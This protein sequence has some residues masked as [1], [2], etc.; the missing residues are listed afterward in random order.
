MAPRVAQ[1][2][3]NAADGSKRLD[4]QQVVTAA[5][6][7]GATTAPAQPLIAPENAAH[8]ETAQQHAAEVLAAR[9]S[10]ARRPSIAS[11]LSGS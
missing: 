4:A 11:R 3:A 2:E 5:N 9:A 7:T 10:S 1:A 6:A 8:E